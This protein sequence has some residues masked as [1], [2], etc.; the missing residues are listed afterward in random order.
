MTRRGRRRRRRPKPPPTPQKEIPLVASTEADITEAGTAPP[1]GESIP[2]R[3]QA[4][5]TSDAT[6]EDEADVPEL[7]TTTAG[8]FQH[9]LTGGIQ[10][11]PKQLLRLALIGYVAGGSWLFLQD[12]AVGRLETEAGLQWFLVKLGYFSVGALAVIVAIFLVWAIAALL[13]R[14]RRLC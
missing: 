13:G 9:L 6:P 14:Q 12:N 5:E 10:V 1:E 11:G 4:G 7:K 3:W 8:L 2:D